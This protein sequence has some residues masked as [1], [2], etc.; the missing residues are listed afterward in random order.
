MCARVHHTQTHTHTYTHTHACTHTHTHTHI[1]IT[2]KIN[3]MKFTALSHV[4]ELHTVART[5]NKSASGEL[6]MRFV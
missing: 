3:E 2:T 1:I 6:F 4:T 5:V